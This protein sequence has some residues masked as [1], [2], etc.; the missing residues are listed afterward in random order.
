MPPRSRN[1]RLPA[2]CDG[3]TAIAASSLVSPLP[4]SRQN[5]RSTSRR[6]DGLP[7]DFIGARPVNSVIQP[8]GLPINTSTLEVL[9]RPVE[10]AKQFLAAVHGDRWYGLYAVALSLGLRR[11]EALGLRWRDVDLVDGVIRIEHALHRV[12]GVLKLGPVKTDGSARAVPVP[13]PLLSV[14]RRHRG[15]QDRE[16]ELAGRPGTTATTCSRP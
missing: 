12:A 3:P 16:R 15:Q 11:G 8:A 4:I 9:R 14:L 5:N 10:S 13:A 1:Q 7:G 6:N 2:A